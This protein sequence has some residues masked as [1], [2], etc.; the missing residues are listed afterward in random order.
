MTAQSLAEPVC[1]PRCPCHT[2]RESA[3]DAPV[4]DQEATSG[5]RGWSTKE[6]VGKQIQRRRLLLAAQRHPEGMGVRTP[7]QS[8]LEAYGLPWKSGAIVEW[9]TSGRG[10][11]C[12]S[13]PHWLVPLRVTGRDFH[14]N[15]LIPVCWN[16][17]FL[18]IAIGNSTHTR[19]GCFIPPAW[20]NRIAPIS[21]SLPIS[22][23]FCP[24]SPGQ[25]TDTW[26]GP[27]TEVGTKPQLNPRGCTI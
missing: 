9:H 10:C 27:S 18:S 3:L 20:T 17:L 8:L 7:Q 5:G 26:G 11:H 2:P 25:G 13:L 4:W 15:K 19:C 16:F 12:N 14:Q 21:L 23:C 6:W 1:A 22:C 24:F